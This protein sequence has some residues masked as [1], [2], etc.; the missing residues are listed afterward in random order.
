M[1][2]KLSGAEVVEIARL[3]GSG[4]SFGQAAQRSGRS[5]GTCFSI[6]HR[7]GG[8]KPAERCPRKD[9]LTLDDRIEIQLGIERGISDS[10]IGRHLG[11]HRS[12]IGR[13]INRNGGRA[14]YRAGIAHHEAAYRARRPKPYKL[15]DVALCDLVSQYLADDFSPQQ[16]SY[17][18]E[19]L[20]SDKSMRV[21]HETMYRSLYVQT[22]GTLRKELT[23]HLRTKRTA[24]KSGQREQTRGQIKNMVNISQRPPEVEDRAVPGHWEGDLIMG[25]N[26]GSAVVTLKERTTRFTMFGKLPNGH[27]TEEVTACL[28]RLVGRLPTQLRISLTWDQ[29]KEMADHQKFTMDTNM[30]VYFCDPHSPWQRGSN[31]NLNGLGRQYMPKGTDLSVHSQED[32]DNYARKI[33]RRPRQTLGWMK[34]ALAFQELIDQNVALTG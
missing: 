9:Q 22:R 24:R 28:K 18:L 5:V 23:Q 19:R 2:G 3:V 13:E 20:F 12:T 4:F 21:S 25:K 16:I 30:S 33:N 32:L 7:F 31:E 29:G 10:A 8:M 27:S 26:N 14:H 11:Y 17:E 6:G 34:P 1:A 15:A